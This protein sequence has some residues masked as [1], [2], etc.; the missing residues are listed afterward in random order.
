MRVFESLEELTL[1]DGER[2][3]GVY[4]PGLRYN[5]WDDDAHAAL[6]KILEQW[7]AEGLA[8]I[9]E[10]REDTQPASVLGQGEIK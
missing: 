3:V 4:V 10:E 6:A 7:L 5:C 9:I 2:L 8:K 1:Y